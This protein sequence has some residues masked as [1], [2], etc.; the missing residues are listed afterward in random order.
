MSLDLAQQAEQPKGAFPPAFEVLVV[1][2][3]R[4]ILSLVAKFLRAN[5]FRVHTARSGPEMT[6]SL[7]HA[8]IDLIVLDLML[9]GRDGLEVTR[10]LRA[11][12]DVPIVMVTQSSDQAVRAEA[13]DEV[14]EIAGQLKG[15]YAQGVHGCGVEQVQRGLHRGE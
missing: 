5:G 6:E 15:L 8:A 9:P 10:E 11:R 2:D 1:D 3:D 14:V 12:T 13:L 7:R 4:E